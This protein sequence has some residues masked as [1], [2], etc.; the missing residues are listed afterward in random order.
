[1]LKRLWQRLLLVLVLILGL[2]AIA[3]QLW[4]LP[5]QQAKVDRR[6]LADGS[7]A[8]LATPAGTAKAQ[9]LLLLDPDQHLQD[10]ELLALA[11][12]SGAHILQL[13]LPGNDC[14]AQQHRLQAATDA[15]QHAPTLVAGIGP[16]AAFAWRWLATQSNDEAQALSVGFSLQQPDCA[17]PLPERAAHGRWNVAW[18]NNPDDPSA[19]FA[20]AQANAQTSISDYSTQLP[21]LLKQ[22]LLSLLQGQGEPIPVIEVAASQPGDTVTLFYSGDG[23]WR[24]LD[25]D[26]AAEMA[27]RGYPVVG[28]DALRYFWQHKSPQ[29][30]AAD[31]GRLMRQYREKWG[32]KRFVLAGYSFGADALPAFYNRL[33]ADEQ[34]QVDA[35]LLL[36]LA[37]SGSFQIEVQGWLGKTGQEAATGPELSR[38]PA[39]KVLCIY[40]QEEGPESGCTQPNAVG[41]AL[42]LPGGHH[43]DENYPA[44]ADKLLQAI[45]QRQANGHND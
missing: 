23:G 35:I 27:K 40:G 14:D 43:Y 22:R 17:A 16:G 33:T 20:R 7:S 15:L 3:W 9:V 1:M 18:N 19:G 34:Q 41:E 30:G 29:Q 2:S 5:A 25:R 32:A 44:L 4:Q 12:D 36:A 42:K 31:L 6:Q 26:V 24:D 10:G 45:Q 21:E 11:Q 13:S 28:I 37:R 39:H 8:S 38:L